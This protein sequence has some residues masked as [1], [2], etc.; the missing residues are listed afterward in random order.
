MRGTV[1]R[2][3]RTVTSGV[4]RPGGETANAT[5]QLK[6][7]LLT[8]LIPSGLLLLGS[9]PGCGSSGALTTGHEVSGTLTG[10]STYAFVEPQKLDEQ[11]FTSGH[12]FNPIMQRRIR[13]EL[14]RELAQRGYTP[15]TADSASML[16]TFS[17]GSRQD[18]VTQGDQKGTVVRGP[19]YTVDQASLVLHFLDPQTNKVIWRGWGNGVM[20][21]DDDLDQ[22]VRAA[23][24]EIMVSFPAT[25][26]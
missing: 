3:R 12:L 26:S 17:A 7:A 6:R 13:D 9:L 8:I 20:T 24:R 23:V 2:G 4:R 19:A 15:S 25:Q 10:R 11:G 14:G 21:A 18:V 16:V 5:A 22:K 1:V